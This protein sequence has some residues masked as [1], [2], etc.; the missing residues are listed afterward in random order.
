MWW[1][2]GRGALDRFGGALALAVALFLSLCDIVIF[3][4][5]GIQI[6]NAIALR[7]SCFHDILTRQGMGRLVQVFLAHAVLTP[8][9]DLI[10]VRRGYMGQFGNA[11]R[12][13]QATGNVF[14]KVAVLKIGLVFRTAIVHGGGRH[15]MRQSPISLVG[16]EHGIQIGRIANI[17]PVRSNHPVLDMM[18][19]RQGESGIAL[20]QDTAQFQDFIGN[21]RQ[22]FPGIFTGTLI[23]EGW[24]VKGNTDILVVIKA[25]GNGGMP[26][27]IDIHERDGQE[28]VGRLQLGQRSHQVLQDVQ[29][30][31]CAGSRVLVVVIG[32]FDSNHD[33]NFLFRAEYFD[34]FAVLDNVTG[35]GQRF[36]GTDMTGIAKVIAQ[37]MTGTQIKAAFAGHGNEHDALFQ[38]RFQRL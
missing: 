22:Q 30:G 19:G 9:N 4:H 34:G 5:Q 29:D 15:G 25:I 21:V 35:P 33:I 2:F 8:L 1:S 27:G 36:Q 18:Q 17:G 6:R 11:S 13:N 32:M 38:V 23:K 16:Q 26:D 20:L 37:D 12:D 28:I 24:F 14:G 3:A 7:T 10:H 31:L